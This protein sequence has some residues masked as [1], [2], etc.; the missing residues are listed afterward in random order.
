MTLAP[1]A[2][3]L[4]EERRRRQ[5]A[6]A[7]G[8]AR[9]DWL[10]EPRPIPLLDDGRVPHRQRLAELGI[11]RLVDAHTHWFP[12][13]VMRKIWAYFHQHNWK[14]SYE[15]EPA[16]RLEWMRR[17]GV[18]RFTTLNY[19]HRPGMAAW[20]N[21]WTAE[22]AAATP[23][24]IPCGTFYAEPDAGA[25]VRRA[26]EDYRFRGFKLHVRVGRLA[27]TDPL[28]RPALEQVEAAGLPLIVHVGSAPEG[29]PFTAPQYVHG[30]LAQHP[31]LRVV[32]AHMGAWEFEEY[33]NLA[34]QRDNVYLDTTMVFV[35][36]SACDPF[37]AALLPRLEALSRKILFGSDF[38]IIPYP[39]AHAVA[40]ILELPLDVAAKRR[41]LGENAERLFGLDDP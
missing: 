19:A 17:N 33:L 38:P 22:F 37:P 24:A 3:L 2:H 7:S 8:A 36:F 18:A 20:L 11:A 40:G 27:L 4:W 23:E 15:T 9:F 1:C 21:D 28:L 34:E 12:Q 16:R 39:Y 35:G 14:T 6:G 41:M 25:Y 32:V 26:I 13:N 29:S 31:R 30:M 10:D 5:A